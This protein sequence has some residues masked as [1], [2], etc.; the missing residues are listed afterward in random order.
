MQTRTYY[1]NDASKLDYQFD[2]EASADDGGPWLTGGDTISSYTLTATT[3]TIDSDSNDTTTI[4]VWVEGTSGT[5][6]ADVT[7]TGGREESFIMTFVEA[8]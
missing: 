5:I 8:C 2:L 1:K 3:V 7:T 6:Q 4:T